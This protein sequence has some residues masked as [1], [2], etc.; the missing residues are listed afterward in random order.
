MFT[1][2][3]RAQDEMEKRSYVLHL[4]TAE[5]EGEINGRDEI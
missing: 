3:I 5:T 2:T 4:H 1:S